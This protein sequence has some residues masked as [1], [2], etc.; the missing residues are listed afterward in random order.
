MQTVRNRQT[1]IFSA[2][3][4]LRI[5]A[6]FVA[7][8]VLDGA[9]VII[10][11]QEY[12]KE[13]AG[14]VRD[15]N[16]G[17]VVGA[18]VEIKSQDVQ[19][20]RV[21]TTNE[22]GEFTFEK[23][24][25]GVYQITVSVNNFNE[26]VQIINIGATRNF[27]CVLQPQSIAAYVSVIS[28]YLAGTPE[29]LARTAGSIETINKETLENARV[30]NFSEALRKV[31]GVNI[32]DE[33]GFGLRPNIGIRG[34][35][36]TRSTKILLLEDGIPLAYAPYGD[37]AS[38][39]HPPIE[40]FESV[41]V[42]K[43]AGQIEYGPVT[44]AGVVNYITSNPS[45]KPNFSLKLIGGN[46]DY[47]NGSAGFSG[48][49]GRTGVLL[50][51]TRKQGAGARE[52]I[53][54]GLNDFSSKIVQTFDDKNVLT[55]K[56]SHYNEDSRLT[57]TG[58]T[59]AEFAAN[60]RGNQFRNDSF[61]LFREGL[62]L[63]H[64]I[65]FT[66]KASLTTNA[67]TSYFSRDWWRQSSN[68]NERPNRLG[69]DPDC[70]GLQDLDTTCGNQGRLRDYRIYGVE[71]R[72]NLHFSL[73]NI[74]SDLN[75]GFRAH[76]EN[77][78]R[79][80]RNGDL[81]NSRDGVLVESNIRQNSAYSG[82]VQNR[83]IWKNFSLTPGIRIENI[84]FKRTNRLNNTNGKPT[85]TQV[86]PGIGATLN[87]FKNTTFFAG[88]HRGFAPPATSDIITNN[89]GV[90]DL[91]PELS[92]NY[93]IGVRTRP[94]NGLSLES[95]FFRTDYENQVVPA[96]LAGGIGA[97]LTNGGQTLHQGFELSAQ[98]DSTNLFKT[99]YN[100]YF[101]TAYTFLESAEFRG[102]RFSQIPGF[103][104]VSVAENRLPYAPKNLLTSS[105]GYAYRNFD[106]FIESNYIGK[107]F[108]DDLNTVNPSVNGQRGAIQAQTYWNATANYRVEKWKT[109]LFV[110]AKNIFD[111]TFVV[112]RSR[113]ILTSSPRLLQTGVKISF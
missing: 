92:W 27:E 85:L 45:E 83:F 79:R 89:G 21:A 12:A 103:T 88:A 59:E 106:A 38:Y 26:Q 64:T 87:L 1:N 20:K 62:S 14:R 29:S 100:V 71:P 36:P 41:E 93:E 75:V 10:N 48:T 94:I 46:R 77:Q 104:N 24:P 42:L 99:S 102:V 56:Y 51:Y 81:P 70:R 3:N 23:L 31:S 43:G 84:K 44:V 68:S 8:F 60:P 34:T 74:R 6:I 65:A 67:Y 16:G 4:I 5:S 113:G 112:D 52:N 90:V 86:I 9:S 111:R 58:L 55:F 91:Q 78:D 32:R 40:R 72:F 108:S 69:S 110:T 63:S 97:I 105:I 57:Y 80:Q 2:H 95:T 39:Y 18:N 73:G 7:L 107:Q 13:F 50:N 25:K 37:N 53:R 30:F 47:F 33:E 98:I 19:F 61:N 96:S 11:A 101:R 109:V 35:N 15:I 76:Y 22:Q 17:V 28:N 66:P 54:S 82:F 49:F